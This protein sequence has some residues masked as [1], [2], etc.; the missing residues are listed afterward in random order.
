MSSP[1]GQAVPP[2]PPTRPKASSPIGQW[3]KSPVNGHRHP[4]VLKL[5]SCLPIP[6]PR[7]AVEHAYL[8]R[9][10]LYAW[11]VEQTPRTGLVEDVGSRA[12]AMLVGWRGDP[13]TFLGDLRRVGLVDR[14]GRLADWN[15]ITGAVSPQHE[16]RLQDMFRQRKWR[17]EHD[18]PD[19]AVLDGTRQDRTVDPTVN[20][21]T[22]VTRDVTVPAALEERAPG[23]R[24]E[25]DSS[26]SLPGAA[27]PM[28]LAEGTTGQATR[29]R[30]PRR[31]RKEPGDD[32]TLPAASIDDILMALPEAARMVSD[33]L[34]F[35][36]DAVAA[37]AI[38]TEVGDDP[39]DL[40]TWDAT[41]G[42]WATATKTGGGA[43]HRGPNALPALFERFRA[44]RKAR[45]D[46][47]DAALRKATECSPPASAT[48]GT[49]R[50]PGTQSAPDV[51]PVASSAGQPVEPKVPGP[52]VAA[53]PSEK[54]PAP[55]PEHPQW[56]VALLEG[57]RA[58]TT[59]GLALGLIANALPITGDHGTAG[60]SVGIGVPA[61]L[62][63]MW[64]MKGLD[65]LAL[66]VADRLGL[67][68]T[69]RDAPVLDTLR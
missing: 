31:P 61:T 64:R 1:W 11:S 44:N 28:P 30:M 16:L 58:G 40:D 47:M 54:P 51:T 56:F 39:D 12:L 57:M 14:Y 45:R 29:I 19:P 10:L 60:T 33:R 38:A 20:R 37:D 18:Q 34:R 35:I 23:A 15:F 2:P 32:A 17:Q 46:R 4:L 68:L 43:Y 21:D 50:A 36:P 9:D 59:D 48:S 27:R 55:L 7:S 26:S 24:S 63:R 67:T 69:I 62:L 5:A 52:A 8:V 53:V 13:D 6:D 41:L 65:A 42:K 22:G 25:T 3:M 66:G 49:P